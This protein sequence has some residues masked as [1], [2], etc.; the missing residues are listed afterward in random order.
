M[1]ATAHVSD[2]HFEASDRQLSRSVT[3]VPLLFLSIGTIIGSGWLFGVLAAD[4]IAGPAAVISWIIG[5]VFVLLIAL[6]YAEIAGLLPRTGALVRYQYLT[7]GGLTGMLAGWA[8]LLGASATAPIEAEAVTTYLGGKFASLGLSTTAQGVQVLTGRGIGLAVALILFFFAVNYVGVRFLAELNRW[9]VW[10]K[11]TIPTLTFAF[12]FVL[13]R[14]SNFT[15]LPGG[16][17]PYGVA[18][19]LQALPLAGVVFAYTGFRSAVE[20][21]GE[22]RRPQRDVPLALVLSLAITTVIYVLLQVAFTGA[23]N[24]GI[25]G[26]K[27]GNWSGLGGTAWASAPFYD[28]LSTAG[29][30]ALGAFATVLLIDAAISPGGTGYI[31]MGAGARNFYGMSVHDSLPG[32]FRRVSRRGIPWVGLVATLVVGLLFLV[33]VPSWY[34]LVGYVTDATVFTYILGGPILMTLR[35][36]A[37]DLHRPF[38]LPAAE[39]VA[40][41]GYLAALMILFWSGF[42]VLANVLAIVFVALPLYAGY[43]APRKGWIRPMV[44]RALAVLFLADWI[45]VNRLGGWFLATGS[46]PAAGAVAFPV[47]IGLFAGSTVL[48]TAAAWLASDAAGRRHVQSSLWLIALLLATLALSYF[49]SYG[50]QKSPLLPFP[51]GDLIE[52]VVGLAA[53]AWG[54][55][56]GF[57]TEE[58]QEILDAADPATL[59]A[60]RP[61]PQAHAAD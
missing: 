8:Y 59:P 58:M 29:I 11:L 3:F 37:A 5:G 13:F 42:A 27:L 43:Y 45:V 12:L 54:V 50:P 18:P 17:A 35:R 38:R 7:F 10:W 57:A 31:G 4:S 39:I 52:V 49:S 22:T 23:V 20:F 25:V 15:A 28:A 53:Y 46:T 36:T 60:P 6:T 48:F 32:A 40:P 34:K 9:V 61:L 33:P 19:I 2:D 55:R 47:F 1:A 24:F 16:F 44:G 51:A 41:L 56:S 30:G 26:L 21:G 14:A